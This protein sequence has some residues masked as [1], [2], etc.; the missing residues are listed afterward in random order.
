MFNYDL[1]ILVYLNLNKMNKNKYWSANDFLLYEEN[2][3]I[4]TEEDELLSLNILDQD[5]ANFDYKVPRNTLIK[6]PLWAA[7]VLQGYEA[8]SINEPAFL[9]SKFESQLSTD[10]TIIN[11]KNKNSYFYDICLILI[12][13]IKEKEE[14]IYNWATLIWNALFDRFF[15]LFKNSKNLLYENYSLLKQ[16]CYREKEFFLYMKGKFKLV[17]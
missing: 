5:N 17:T 8:V 12:P 3:T 2:V 11:F 1:E 14:K 9:G 15:Y 13:Q 10:C 16:L 6:L 4:T 7:V